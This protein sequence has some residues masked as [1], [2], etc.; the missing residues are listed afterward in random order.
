[1]S[2]E[3]CRVDAVPRVMW[4]LNHTSARNIEIPMLKSIGYKEIFLPKSYPNDI[5]FRSASTEW[6]EDQYLTIPPEE[7]SILNH[8]NWYE[9]GTRRS[10]KVANKYF[11]YLF[12]ILIDSDIAK[13]FERHFAGMVLWRAYG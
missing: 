7:L 9:G 1:M 2:L 12:F 13:Q 6:R 8:T 10:R 11:D 4:L 3:N 5:S